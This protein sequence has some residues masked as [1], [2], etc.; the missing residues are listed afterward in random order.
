MKSRIEK[1][2]EI[3]NTLKKE[4][5]NTRKKEKKKKINNFIIF[6]ITI[7]CLCIVY[8]RCIEPNIL[9]T[10]E[11]KI[12]SDKITTEF[13][14]LKIVQFS[15]L[16]YGST[17]FEKQLNKISTEIAKLKP[18]IIIFTGD[19]IDERYIN[20]LTK[21]DQVILTNFLS[22]LDS[23]LGKYAILGNH[24]YVNET[25]NNNILFDSNFVI[26]K[27]TYDIIYNKSGNTIG[28]FGF[29]DI[30]EGSPDSTLLISD[31]FKNANYK[32]VLVHEPDYIDSFINIEEFD[33]I[34]AGH[35]HDCQVKLP[36][37]KPFWLPVGAKTYY[38]EKYTI[39]NTK[40]YIS[41]GIGE[42]TLNLR[43][44]SPPS[45][46]LFRLVKK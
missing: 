33:L 2:K 8:A 24:D 29:D 40:I 32:I 4:K 34:L 42:S 11:Y 39:N 17:I 3:D 35:S 20:K 31:E 37:I 22:N 26:L 14:G 44:F 21:K 9:F 13:H 45:I 27:N 5:I 10:K 12:T 23:N 19:L 38:K 41:N 36:F 43:F 28:I 7:F 15:D 30:L 18:D 25:V 16:H 1:Y 6:I 46:N